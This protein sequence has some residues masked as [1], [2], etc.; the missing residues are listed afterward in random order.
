[1]KPLLS[2]LPPAL[3]L[4]VSISCGS[5]PPVSQ[6]E[7]PPDPDPRARIREMSDLLAGATAL[8]LSA[9]EVHE[10]D[11]VEGKP[12]RLEG[13]QTV[14]IQRPDRLYIRAKG[15][16]FRNIDHELFYD[17]QTLTLAN[18]VQNVWASAA[19]PATID[20]MLDQVSWRFNLPIPLADMMYSSPFDAVMTDSTVVRFVDVEVMGGLRCDHF[21]ATQETVDWEIWISADGDPLPR[22]LDIIHKNL[23]G[24]PRSQIEFSSVDLA[25]TPEVSRFVFTPKEGYHQI[26]VVENAPPNGDP[27][28]SP[29]GGTDSA[30]E[31]REE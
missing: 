14:V 29:D 8:T 25:S 18:H 10:R 26:P 15:K 1:M 19:V 11:T 4:L 17:G 2:Y 9:H 30:E 6:A 16:G 27:P 5:P 7:P 28:A 3:F 23:E 22:K 21:A 31:G 24:T 13:E 12:E 20:E